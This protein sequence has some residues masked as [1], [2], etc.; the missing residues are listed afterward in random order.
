[1][2]NKEKYLDE[3][4]TIFNENEASC[5]FKKKYV[6][7]NCNDTGCIKCEELFKI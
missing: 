2:K 6:V 4:L 1:M 5:F 7:K 3:M